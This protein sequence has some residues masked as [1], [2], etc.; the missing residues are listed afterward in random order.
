VATKATTK[1]P[2][3]PGLNQQFSTDASVLVVRTQSTTLENNN[4]S[5]KQIRIYQVININNRHIQKTLYR[6]IKMQSFSSLSAFLLLL[7]AVSSNNLASGFVVPLPESTAT[8]SSSSSLSSALNAASPNMNSEIF[9]QINRSELPKNAFR[10]QSAA[11]LEPFMDVE[12]NI[13]R[14][15]MVVAVIFC[16]VELT[17]DMS[18]PEQLAQIVDLS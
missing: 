1:Q 5:F 12:V 17:T 4:Q 13:G 3:Q 8:L 14:F 16:A 10:K 6:I 15:A 11:L 9:P 2:N 7:L 18:I